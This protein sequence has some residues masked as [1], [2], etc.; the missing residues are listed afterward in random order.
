M[1]H[2]LR[3]DISQ[4]E[5][6]SDEE[7]DFFVSSLEVVQVT[8]GEF[9]LKEGQICTH[10]AF[11]EKG[12]AMYYKVVD[13][14]E[15]PL[16]FAI[17]G[18]WITYLKSFTNRTPSDMNIKVLEDATLFTL[19]AGKMQELMT[20]YPKFLALRSYYVEKSLA[21]VTQHSANLATLDA[22][23]RYYQL[24][25]EK[26]YLINRVP[27]Y[28]LAAYLGIKPQSLSRIRKE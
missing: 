9:F 5:R 1:Y 16:D 3:K 14:T 6:Y 12:L 10:I 7:L 20:K 13:G 26:P 2:N 25:K 28:Y 8:K 24:M 22:K 15:I 23:G 27:Q 4:V 11:V 17:E 21:E 18:Q 19:E